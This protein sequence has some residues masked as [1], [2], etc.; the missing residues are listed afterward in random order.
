MNLSTVLNH[1]IEV[2]YDTSMEILVPARVHRERRWMR[3]TC[4]HRRVQ[5][6]WNKRWGFVV[7]PSVVFD[8][9]KGVVVAHPF[10]KDVIERELGRHWDVF[11]ELE[12]RERCSTR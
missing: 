9:K 3:E 10:F 7:Q 6:K 4:Y 12:R 2:V 8:V 11:L 1:A 5:K